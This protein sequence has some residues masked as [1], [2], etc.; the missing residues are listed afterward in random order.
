MG[1]LVLTSMQKR[2]ISGADLCEV[3]CG[4]VHNL[5]PQGRQGD[6]DATSCWHL[7]LN[8]CSETGAT[9]GKAVIKLLARH[10]QQT[11]QNSYDYYCTAEN[12]DGYFKAGKLQS[13]TSQCQRTELS[14]AGQHYNKDVRKSTS[15]NPLALTTS[16]E[17]KP[18]ARLLSRQ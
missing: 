5:Q 10:H 16:E 9:R 2:K 13:T 8:A 17:N 11:P 18:P 12:V 6:A 15:W 1:F 7:Q 3:S 4:Q 14:D